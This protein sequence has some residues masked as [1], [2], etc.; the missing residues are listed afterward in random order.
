MLQHRFELFSGDDQQ[1][2]CIGASVFSRFPGIAQIFLRLRQSASFEASDLFAFG[3]TRDVQTTTRDVQITTTI[4]PTTTTL[5]IC[6]KLV[7][8]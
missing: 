5:E 7:M 2:V 4:A 1:C 8:G 3:C 6:G